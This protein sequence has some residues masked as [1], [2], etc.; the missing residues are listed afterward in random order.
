VSSGDLRFAQP[1]L[2]AGVAAGADRGQLPVLFPRLPASP[3]CACPGPAGQLPD[4]ARLPPRGADITSFHLVVELA[5][6]GVVLAASIVEPDPPRLWIDC[7]LGWPLLA[8]AW[9]DWQRLRLPDVLT[10]V[11]LAGLGVTSLR[12][13]DSIAEHAA[14]AIVAYA[15]LQGL[16]P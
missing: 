6:I 5:A 4:P 16:A 11:L 3:L 14:A 15:S 2:A 9:T 10:L 8:V 7:L 12:Q 13:P 1:P